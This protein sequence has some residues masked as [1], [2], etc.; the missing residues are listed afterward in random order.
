MGHAL[1]NTI[2]DILVGEPDNWVIRRLDSG[3]DHAGI[4]T[5]TK[6]EQALARKEVKEELGRTI[7]SSMR[8]CGETSMEES[9]F[10]NCAN[11][12]VPVI[13]TGMFTPWTTTIPR[14]SSGLCQ[15]LQERIRLPRQRMVNW[16]PASLTALSDEEVIMKPQNSTLQDQIRIWRPPGLSSR[17]PPPDPK[18]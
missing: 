16:C 9:S 7:F 4:A 11:W 10:G 18:P 1:N 17:F 8:L 3:T 14:P 2:Q 12:G 6:V 5:Q 13:G 15:T